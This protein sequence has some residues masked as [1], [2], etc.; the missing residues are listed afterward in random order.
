ME[1]AALA[2]SAASVTVAYDPE[3]RRFVPATLQARVTNIGQINDQFNVDVIDLPDDWT[4]RSVPGMRMRPGIDGTVEI[5]FHP[6]RRPESTAGPHAFKVRVTPQEQPTEYVEY[7]ATLII[8]PFVESALSLVEPLQTTDGDAVFRARLVNGGNVPLTYAL[9]ALPVEDKAKALAISFLSNGRNEPTTLITVAPGAEI[10]PE[11]RVSAPPID[12]VDRPAGPYP[13]A[14]QATAVN[15]GGA[16]PA[17][18]VPPLTAGGTLVLKPLAPVEV[19]IEPARVELIDLIVGEADCTLRVYNPSRRVVGVLLEARAPSADYELKLEQDRLVLAPESVTEVKLG[20]RRSPLVPPTTAPLRQPFQ[21]TVRQVDLPPESD[22]SLLPAP[23]A[24]PGSA[25]FTAPPPIEVIIQPPGL[26]LDLAP[27]RRRGGRGRYRVTMSNAGTQRVRARLD[28]LDPDNE[29]EYVFGFQQR[30]LKELLRRLFWRGAVP[31]AQQRVYGAMT[32]TM[33]QVANAAGVSG[34]N[35]QAPDE[36]VA[37]SRAFPIVIEPQGKAEVPLEVRPA[38]GQL[39]GRSKLYPFKVTSAV[40]EQ[41]L[42]GLTREAEFEHRPL[43]VVMLLLILLLLISPLFIIIPLKLG[44][45]RGTLEFGPYCVPGPLPVAPPVAVRQAGASDG[46][47]TVALREGSQI[48]PVAEEPAAV[49]PGQFAKLTVPSPDKDRVLYVTAKDALLNGAT[50]MVADRTGTKSQLKALEKGLWPAKPV[51]CQRQAGDPGRIAYVTASEPAAGRA[52]LQLRVLTLGGSDVQDALV[53]EGTTGA[54]SNGFL[55]E[56]FYGRQETPLQWW[57]N[58]N[59]I[60]YGDAATGRRWVVDLRGEA[61]R[62]TEVRRFNLP[63][64]QEVSAQ[65]A[66]VTT[67]EAKPFAQT[68]PGWAQRVVGKP[69]GPILGATGCT[70]AAAA[71]VFK[72]YGVNTNPNQLMGCAADTIDPFRWEAAAQ[73]CGGGKVTGVTW[74]EN[75]SFT[76][77]SAALQARQPAIVGLAGGPT[78]SHYLIAVE[79]Q[80]EAGGDFRVQDPWDG[81]AYKRLSDYLETGTYRLKY[82]VRYEG[83]APVCAVGPGNAVPPIKFSGIQDGGSSQQPVRIQYDAPPGA[84][85]THPSGTSFDKDGFYTVGVTLADGT[86]RSLSFFIDRVAPKTTATWVPDKEK[87]EKFGGLLSF[88]VKDAVTPVALTR[89]K[90]DDGPWQDYTGDGDKRGNVLTRAI[91]LEFEE[92]GEHR[93]RFYSIDA[94]GNKENDVEQAIRIEGTPPTPRIVPGGQLNFGLTEVQKVVTLT[95]DGAGVLRWKA[96]ALAE[97]EWLSVEPAEGTIKA[98]E[99]QKLTVK[100]DRA[101]IKPGD[102][103]GRLSVSSSLGQTEISADVE[104]IGKQTAPPTP[105]PK[106]SPAAA[107][108]PAPKEEGGRGAGVGKEEPAVDPAALTIRAA[109]LT[110]AFSVREAAGAKFEWYVAQAPDWLILEVDGNEVLPNQR[111]FTDTNATTQVRVRPDWGQLRPGESREGTITIR[112]SSN[113]YTATVKVTAQR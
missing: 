39:I 109:Q 1:T 69:G 25:I 79:G 42:D 72:Y 112:D 60:K 41:V 87:K 67:C 86:Y 95:V 35:E 97:G 18:A 108:K 31:E 27:R 91:P 103:V 55:P 98:G 22:P 28:V 64:P 51:W 70:L 62:A 54:G 106:P 8:E 71:T 49:L 46:K 3:G 102:F 68:D 82:L 81:T 36:Q 40:N 85:A 16:G 11:L 12:G 9:S 90:I 52:G 17:L 34:P 77:I 38:R 19:A 66:P 80:G 50:L 23:I 111:I 7:G 76:D 105:A 61:P 89:F 24:A 53:L 113:R 33:T 96:T 37:Q 107:E 29:L 13:F 84:Q 43:P 110:G 93:V 73:K 5:T 48:I 57:D 45:D 6:P 4:S 75:P 100:I 20:V 44:C 58:C 63:G 59:A 99:Q 10:T 26:K 65:A 21:V 94:A 32:S 104:V 92:V 14:L 2:L 74:K 47:T 30:G 83:T 56:I 78:G 101:K 88:A 15:P